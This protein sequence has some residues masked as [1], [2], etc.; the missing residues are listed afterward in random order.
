[1]KSRISNAVGFQFL[2]GGVCLGDI[3]RSSG[4]SSFSRGIDNDIE[5]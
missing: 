2:S 3:R 1:M 4:G 5:A